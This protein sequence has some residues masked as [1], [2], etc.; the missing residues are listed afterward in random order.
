MLVKDAK[1]VAFSTDSVSLLAHVSLT[2]ASIG[3]RTRIPKQKVIEAR[4]TNKQV[5]A[6]TQKQGNQVTEI[7]S[8]M[9]NLKMA[10]RAL[11][12]GHVRGEEKQ[13]KCVP[14]PCSDELPSQSEID[15]AIT[16]EINGTV[17]AATNGTVK[18]PK[19]KTAVHEWEEGIQV[20]NSIA[21]QQ[22]NSTGRKS[23]ADE[24]KAVTEIR[25]KPSI[26]ENFDITRRANVGFK[27]EY[28]NPSKNGETVLCEMKT[29]R[30]LV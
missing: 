16:E 10:T 20:P 4:E 3:K 15:E 28:V 29:R 19:P 2:C 5:S 8:T 21:R 13:G 24:V 25:A 26:W 6:Q 12:I 18:V 22:L 17:M 23:W 27:L 30:H 1:Q 9:S 11:E 7:C 14:E